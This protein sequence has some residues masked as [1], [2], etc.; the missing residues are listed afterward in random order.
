MI[1][2]KL[3]YRDSI[4]AYCDR[5]ARRYPS[6]VS[7]LRIRRQRLVYTPLKQFGIIRLQHPVVVSDES[8]RHRV[9]K[10]P[11]GGEGGFLVFR[12]IRTSD[13]SKL[14]IESSS[15]DLVT[16]CVDSSHSSDEIV[17]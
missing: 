14:S 6:L 13:C 7:H 16:D 17:L 15:S 3:S 8:P 2:A 9:I 4:A 5:I 12:Q 10:G 1:I 11:K